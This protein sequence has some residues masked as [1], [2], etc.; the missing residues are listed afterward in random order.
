[1]HQTSL[2]ILYQDAIASVGAVPDVSIRHQ[3]EITFKALQQKG[4]RIKDYKESVG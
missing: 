1:M 2:P 3:P 4:L